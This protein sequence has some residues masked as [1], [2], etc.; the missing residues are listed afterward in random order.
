M[1]ARSLQ[2]GTV[3]KRQGATREFSIRDPG[4]KSLTVSEVTS[5]S[6]FVKAVLT[7]DEKEGLI[8]LVKAELKPGPDGSRAGAPIGELKTKLTVRS[9]HPKE[10]VVEIPVQAEVVGDIE[11]FPN[12]FFLGLLKKGQTVSKT[13]TLS[14]TAKERLKIKKIVSPADYIEV[15]SKHQ[16]EKYTI[17]ATLKDTAPLGLTKGEV[18]IHTNN[19]DQPEIKVP[20]YALVEE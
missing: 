17:T 4:D 14:T 13:T 6:P 8:Y 19:A 3:R 5:D 12:Q 10:P 16:G 7:R 1:S 15:E 9:N 20:L 2:F 18:V 11:V